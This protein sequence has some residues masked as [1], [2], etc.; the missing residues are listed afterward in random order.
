M[1]RLLSPDDFEYY[2][3]ML[4]EYVAAFAKA[5]TRS[6]AK[7]SSALREVASI[8]SDSNPADRSFMFIWLLLWI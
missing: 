3:E 4:E 5:D 2:A 8:A 1:G 7:L 6:I